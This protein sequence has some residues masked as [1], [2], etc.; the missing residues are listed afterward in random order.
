MV[1]YANIM[2]VTLKKNRISIRSS[3]PEICRVVAFAGASFF[4]PLKILRGPTKTLMPFDLFAFDAWDTCFR[5]CPSDWR[6]FHERPAYRYGA[7]T[8]FPRSLL[9]RSALQNISMTLDW[10]DRTHGPVREYHAG[11]F[12]KNR[13][14]KRSSVP[15]ICRFVAFAGA[16]FFKPFKIFGAPPKP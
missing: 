5:T 14:S 8:V 4:K 9:S 10:G 16:S 2:P 3:V 6:M 15:E 12:K 1:P 13:I 7:V 11:H